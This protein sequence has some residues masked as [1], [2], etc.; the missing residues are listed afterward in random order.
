M[1][2]YGNGILFI[3]NDSLDIDT[4]LSEREATHAKVFQNIK[5][6]WNNNY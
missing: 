6:N 2:Q 1:K 3:S 4:G 5:E